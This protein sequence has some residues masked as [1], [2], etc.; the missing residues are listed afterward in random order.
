MVTIITGYIAGQ[1]GGRTME[2]D[3]TPADQLR[4]VK[5]IAK[6]NHRAARHLIDQ[7]RAC[8]ITPDPPRISVRRSLSPLQRIIRAL[9]GLRRDEFPK[10]IDRSSGNLINRAENNLH[11]YTC[12]IYTPFTLPKKKNTSTQLN[13]ELGFMCVN[14]HIFTA[15]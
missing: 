9:C 6:I 10:T 5:Y 13:T 15:T 11:G 3:R 8:P 4:L 7:I 1:F 2:T 12:T 14:K